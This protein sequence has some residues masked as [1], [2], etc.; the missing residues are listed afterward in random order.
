M[1]ISLETL[2]LVQ[3]SLPLHTFK[4]LENCGPE[5][6]RLAEKGLPGADGM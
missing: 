5:R 2:F 1:T 3:R 6:E 4:Q